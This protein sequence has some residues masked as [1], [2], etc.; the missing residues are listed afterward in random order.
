MI[1][2]L[3]LIAAHGLKVIGG[4]C[5]A[6]IGWKTI[7]KRENFPRLM[8][9]TFIRTGLVVKVDNGKSKREELPKLLSF[10]RKEWGFVFKYRV[11][12]GLSI[13]QFIEKK[14]ILDAAFNGECNIFGQGNEVTIEV[15]RA[16]MPEL[17]YFDIE[18]I[19]KQSEGKAIPFPLGI[20]RKGIEVIDF[21]K[22]PHGINAG[23][24]GGGKSVF[25]RQFLS[26]VALLRTP[27]QI[28]MTL[29]DLKYGMELSLFEKLPHVERFVEDAKDVQK[30][31]DAVNNMMNERGKEFRKAGVRK[32]EQYNA[33]SES[34]LPYHL[35]IIDELAEI[36]DLDTIERISKLGRALGIHM[37]LCTQRPSAK[38]LDGEIKANCPLK[39][40]FQVINGVNSRIIL[41]NENAK[42]LPPVPGRAIVQFKGERQI[43]SLLLEED[44][45][46]ILL[47]PIQKEKIED[48]TA[49]E[50]HRDT[51]HYC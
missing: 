41:D 48:A 23:E 38:I 30:A 43:Q 22:A 18:K 40:C 32:I 24:T 39:L 50:G 25:L 1:D 42:Y 20:T 46:E 49:R 27:D 36:K 11:I 14:A 31:L 10:E 44:H 12:P 21:A 13:Q 51:I 33:K 4:Y 8:R 5:A 3:S 7:P 15:M 28:T 35:L 2:P 26:A 45:A 17:E 47:K 16:P 34:R 19:R 9:L 29:I 6:Y 37:L